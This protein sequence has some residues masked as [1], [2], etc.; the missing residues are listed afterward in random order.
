MIQ[1]LLRTTVVSSGSGNKY[2]HLI[3]T[4][5]VELQLSEGSFS[6]MSFSPII[7]WWQNKHAGDTTWQGHHSEYYK[8]RM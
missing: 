4:E 3:T 1:R 7:C 6:F 8:T 5:N 2:V